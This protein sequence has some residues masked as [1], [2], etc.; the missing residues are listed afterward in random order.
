MSR[1]EKDI[2][3]RDRAGI[4]RFVAFGTDVPLGWTYVRDAE[5][6][7]LP[8]HALQPR[9]LA[10]ADAIAVHAD[11]ARTT[12]ERTAAGEATVRET[13]PDH[14]STGAQDTGAGEPHGIA[15]LPVNYDDMGVEDLQAEAD[16]RGLEVEGTGANGNVLKKDLVDA[17]KATG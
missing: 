4:E 9:A 6:A 13:L 8:P 12:A 15:P 17:L 14:A 3:A 5:P 1:A 7:A 10:N 2:I 16:R 11:A